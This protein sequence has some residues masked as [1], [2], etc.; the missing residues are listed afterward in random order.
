MVAIGYA[1]CCQSHVPNDLVRYARL[2]EEAGF[3]FAFLSD[4]L[5]PWLEEQGRSPFLWSIVGGIAQATQ[6]LRLSTGVICPAKYA[7]PAMIAQAAATAAAMMPGRFALGI[8]MAGNLGEHLLGPSWPFPAIRPEILEETVQVIRLLWRGGLQNHWGRHYTMENVCVYT[9]TEGLPAILIAGNEPRG[10]ELAGRL[11]DGLI[12]NAPDRKLVRR[13]EEAGGKGKPRYGKVTVCWAP[14][15]AE[16]CRAAHLWWQSTAL[17]TLAFELPLPAYFVKAIARVS[18][19]DITRAI[20][21]SADAARHIAAIREYAEAGYDHVCVH[22]VGPDQEGF[23]RFYQR[24][25]LPAFQARRPQEGQR[26][27]RPRSF[28]KPS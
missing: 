24:E 2:A 25:V 6:R 23:I 8:G 4:H 22:Q 19:V 15:A 27:A 26:R 11:G 17:H 28:R 12:G 20:V 21:C 3:T 10:A 5:H 13:F 18:E 16:A 7:H 9:P 1:L 14:D